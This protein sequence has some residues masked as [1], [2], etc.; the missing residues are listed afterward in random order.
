MSI[1]S[2]VV[3]VEARDYVSA[4]RPLVAAGRSGAR[5]DVIIMAAVRFNVHR[6]SP[7]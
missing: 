1:S 6:P 5:N 7:E 3:G 4:F 2:A